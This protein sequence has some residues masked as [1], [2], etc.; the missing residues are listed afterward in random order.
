MQAASASCG[1]WAGA[2]PSLLA[3]WRWGEAGVGEVSRAVPL[4]KWRYARC[5][6]SA[7]PSIIDIISPQQQ[8]RVLFLGLL[9][10]AVGPLNSSCGCPVAAY[11]PLFGIQGVNGSKEGINW[12]RG[13]AWEAATGRLLCTGARAKKHPP[14]FWGA[15][16]GALLG[17][18]FWVLFFGAF[19]L[20]Y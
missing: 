11:W 17:A 2:W 4:D 18:L 9:A 19:V 15:L 20:Y 5:T 16:L 12:G 7:E 8:Q 13:C 14:G 1:R 10:A 3:A 6:H